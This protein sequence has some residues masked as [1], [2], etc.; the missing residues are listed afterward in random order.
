MFRSFSKPSFRFLDDLRERLR[1]L[2]NP[3]EKAEARRSPP[4]SEYSRL[5]PR[6]L[7]EREYFR[8]FFLPLTRTTIGVRRPLRL[9]PG[10][11][12]TTGVTCRLGSDSPGAPAGLPALMNSA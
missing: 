5:R 8:F 6:P 10:P 9:K 12:D 4:L 3:A 2:R 11:L 1:N 7:S